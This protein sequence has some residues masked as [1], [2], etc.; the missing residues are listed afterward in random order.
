MSQKQ[1]YYDLL[2]VRM[3]SVASILHFSFF[4]AKTASKDDIKRAYRDLARKYHPD[5]SRNDPEATEIFKKL[6]QG[7]SL[8]SVYST[9][10]VCSKLMKFY[11]TQ[12]SGGSMMNSEKILVK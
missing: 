4:S 7:I 8:L 5:R 3:S 9:L 1:S 10:I 2:G 12:L 11:P 6:A